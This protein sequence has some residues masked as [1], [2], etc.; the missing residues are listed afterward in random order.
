MSVWDE[1][2][3]PPPL[4]GTPAEPPPEGPP[5]TLPDR[6][7][8]DEPT[9]RRIL[10]LP[11][12]VAAVVGVVICLLI[13]GVIALT[14]DSTPDDDTPAGAPSTVGIADDTS[15]TVATNTT[16]PVT[17]APATTAPVTT[18]PVAAATTVAPSTTPASTSTST[19]TSTSTSTTTV[20]PTTVATT[21]PSGLDPVT[22]TAADGR[23]LTVTPRLDSCSGGD[24]CLVVAF[25]IEGFA[26]RPRIFVCEFASGNRYEFRFDSDR[27]GTACSTGDVPDSIVVEVDGLRSDPITIAD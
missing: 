4:A 8:G 13:G 24:E 9:S 2:P 1:S 14:G 11:R 3:L 23:S 15:T 18:A 20:P 25:T 17:T 16:A 26:T 7:P 5:P 21:D 10:G 12:G 19:T 6:D 27:V 22:V